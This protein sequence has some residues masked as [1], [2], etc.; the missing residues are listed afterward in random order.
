M[1]SNQRKISILDKAAELCKSK[2]YSGFTQANIMRRAQKAGWPENQTTKGTL[3]KYL[4]APEASYNNVPPLFFDVILEMFKEENVSIP[5]SPEDERLCTTDFP[6]VLSMFMNIGDHDQRQARESLPGE[7]W[8][9][10]PS[11]EKKDSIIKFVLRIK[12]TREGTLS[13]EELF[14]YPKE[15][16]SDIVKQKSSGF[17]VGK[18]G[19]SMM[20][21][22]DPS[23]YLP[24]I[25][26]LRNIMGPSNKCFSLSGGTMTVNPDT[27]A[28]KIMQRKITC[29]RSKEPIPT[30]KKVL[31][32]EHGMGI[33]T[34]D[35]EDEIIQGLFE[36]LTPKQQGQAF[37]I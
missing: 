36:T 18:T 1:L 11:I 32:E 19:H 22:N 33:H 8:A 10:M 34:K 37:Y 4:N 3:S 2:S 30:D 26:L 12:E 35:T 29:I 6:H 21:L 25:Y 14:Y 5:L 17:I 31:I 20:V 27:D 23:S 24:K 13:A 9:Y 15:G 7:Y 16:F 28:V